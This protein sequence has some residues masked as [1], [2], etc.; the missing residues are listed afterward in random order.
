LPEVT[1]V[2]EHPHAGSGRILVMDDE[3]LIRE[4]AAEIL[5]HLGYSVVVCCDGSEAIAL[6][7]QAIATKEPF[8]AVIMDLTIPAAWGVRRL[9]QDTGDRSRCRIN[10]LQRLFQRSC[11]SQFPS[12]R[13]QRCGTQTI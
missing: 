4:V 3:E 13:L 1:D 6:Y 5:G 12:V 9:R 10:R 7:R 11:H 2:K 8:A